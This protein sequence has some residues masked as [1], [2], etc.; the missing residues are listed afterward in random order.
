MPAI[1][2]KPAARQQQAP[3]APQQQPVAQVQQVQQN[4]PQQPQPP[5]PQAQQMIPGTENLLIFYPPF[6]EPQ[7]FQDERQP[8][9]TME[10]KVSGGG[11]APKRV[12]R[13]TL[14][15]LRQTDGIIPS[16][17]GWNKGDSQKLMTVILHSVVYSFVVCRTLEHRGTP[18]QG[19]DLR[20]YRYIDIRINISICI[21]TCIVFFCQT[22]RK[23][24]KESSRGNRI[25][26][27]ILIHLSLRASTDNSSKPSSIN[28]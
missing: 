7:Q 9:A 14:A 17:A 25:C 6:V 24:K 20:I 28:K 4:G 18:R 2:I 12:G 22:E 13:W 5:P 8:N 11:G 21:Y 15:Q 27:I 19:S 23:R 10:T 26:S 1:A 3:P 16:Q